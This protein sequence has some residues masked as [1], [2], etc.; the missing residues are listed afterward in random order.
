MEWKL[1]VPCLLGLEGP[2]ADELRRMDM[3][4]VAAENG[5]VCF[6]GGAREI[7]R[8][9]VCLRVGERVLGTDPDSGR[10]VSVKI[11]RFGPVVPSGETT[12]TLGR[13]ESTPSAEESGPSGESGENTGADST[14]ESG[15]EGTS[16]AET[17][18]PK[19]LL[20]EPWTIRLRSRYTMKVS[21]SCQLT[22][23]RA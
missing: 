18:A 7:A 15:S 4:N 21:L 6:D 10:T 5:R 11:G 23:E 1:C 3:K 20:T 8:A 14:G 22:L 2:I 12:V 9:N 19:P 17:T 16:P 13:D